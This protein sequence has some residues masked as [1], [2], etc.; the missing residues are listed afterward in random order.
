MHGLADRIARSAIHR[1]HATP[2][3][4]LPP[5]GPI[6]V[7]DRDPAM[8]AM[9]RTA[10][11]GVCSIVVAR[12]AGE[13][14]GQVEW[15]RPEAVLADAGLGAD[16]LDLLA[17]GF[18]TLGCDHLP[19][20]TVDPSQPLGPSDLRRIAA[21]ALGVTSRVWMAGGLRERVAA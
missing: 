17:R 7:G 2:V 11:E 5:R 9:V 14:L 18:A 21:R 3:V 13:A 16:Q 4:D 6:M 12:D 19:I 1:H 10:L 8:L 15:A 20:V